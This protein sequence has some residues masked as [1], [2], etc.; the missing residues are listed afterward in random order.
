[1]LGLSARTQSNDFP[2]D[3]SIGVAHTRVYSNGLQGLS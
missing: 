1:M 2:I 3:S